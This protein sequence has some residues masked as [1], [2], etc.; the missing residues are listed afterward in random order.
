MHEERGDVGAALAALSAGER[1]FGSD[2]PF[3]P[4]RARI[5][6]RANRNAELQRVMAACSA[7]G[8]AELESACADAGQPPARATPVT[9]LGGG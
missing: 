4:H 6:R 2:D 7:K 5:L 9:L 1:R 8:I 3:L